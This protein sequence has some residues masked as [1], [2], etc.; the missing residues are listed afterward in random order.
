MKLFWY[1]GSCS[2]APHIA[3]NELEMK[4]ESIKVDPK[5]KN[6]VLKYNPKGQVPTLALDNEI[7]LSEVSVILQ[8][9]AD[10]YPQSKFLPEQGT[11]ERYRAQ[12]WLNYVATEIHQGLGPMFGMKAP[13]LETAKTYS[14]KRMTSKFDY[15]ESV[16]SKQPYLMGNDYSFAD[17]YL[18]VTLNWTGYL[19]VDISKYSAL[20]KFQERVKNRPAVR[21]TLETEFAK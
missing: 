7:G 3:L 8:Y 18:F 12:E 13:E 9:L 10:L 15:L 20:A 21:R 17:T 5:Q 6:E 14:I 19:N 16:L 2:Q 11:F 1:P 4:F